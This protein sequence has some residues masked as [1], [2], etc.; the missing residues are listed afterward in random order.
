MSRRVMAEDYFGTWVSLDAYAL[1]ADGDA[2]VGADF[3]GGAKAPDERPPGTSGDRSQHGAFLL[4]GEMPGSGGFHFEFAMDLVVVAVE[5]QVLDL[6]IG[7]V[8]VGDLLTGKEGGQALLPKEVTAFDFAFGLRGWG[9]AE[10]DAIEVESLTQLG[11]RMGLLS[12]EDAVIININFQRQPVIDKGGRQ[13]IQISQEPFALIDFGAGKDTAAI[14]E[15]VDHGKELRGVGE[16]L[17]RRGIQ[18]PEF[19]DLAALPTFD[20]SVWTAVRLGVGEVVGEGPA[21]DLSPVQ[22]I[23]A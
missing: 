3:D 15:H 4:A 1:R 10:A 14:I 18:L 6:G 12:E 2:P 19:T 17:A 9:I 23:V 20:R 21:A 11:Q 22:T 7:L 13:E 16:P 5:T 8:E